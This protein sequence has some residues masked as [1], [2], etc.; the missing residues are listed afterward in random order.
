MLLALVAIPP[1]VT[2]LGI[3][4]RVSF[5][6]GLA[7]AASAVAHEPYT[8][9]VI[10]VFGSEVVLSNLLEIAI[11]LDFDVSRDFIHQALLGL[12][13][14]VL[15]VGLAIALHWLDAVGPGSFY[16]G[17]FLHAVVMSSVVDLD[18]LSVYCVVKLLDS[19][20]ALGFVKVDEPLDVELVGRW[21]FL[22]LATYISAAG[23]RLIGFL[24]IVFY[25]EVLSHLCCYQP[26]S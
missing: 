16:T 20:V 25:E 3:G 17:L 5:S 9:Q 8:S 10:G 24:E 6:S 12:V 19:R 4:V 11:V 18:F 26:V 14:D 15:P 1:L 13:E 7:L 22:Q 2:Q 23:Q 21:R